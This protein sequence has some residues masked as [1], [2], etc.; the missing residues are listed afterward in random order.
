MCCTT[1]VQEIP[2][3]LQPDSGN[4]LQTEVQNSMASASDPLSFSASPTIE[5]QGPVE[6]ACGS[7]WDKSLSEKLQRL[8]K[9]SH[10]DLVADRYGV[11]IT[12]EKLKCLLGTEWLNS[13]VIT[14]WLEWWGEQIGAGSEVNMPKSSKLRCYFASTYFF[15]KMTEDGYSYQA[16]K[17]WTKKIDIFALDK[18]IIPMNSGNRHWYLAVIDFRLPRIEIYDS[19]YSTPSAVFETLF[20]W[21]EDEHLSRKGSK[22]DRAAWSCLPQTRAKI[23]RQQNCSDCGVFMCLFAAYSSLDR[24]FRFSQNQIAA[25]RRWMISIIYKV[26]QA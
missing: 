11:K 17:R 12:V 23:P 5:R 14:F 9:R 22:M 7:Q 21:L 19:L 4:R 20:R 25:V 6:L 3:Q 24:P 1:H 10:K 2:E 16:T 18:M 8:G 13:E 15:T 26:G